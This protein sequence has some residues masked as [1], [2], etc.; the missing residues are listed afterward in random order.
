MYL[1]APTIRRGFGMQFGNCFGRAIAHK[2]AASDSYE[3]CVNVSN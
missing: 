3:L 2:H 1:R